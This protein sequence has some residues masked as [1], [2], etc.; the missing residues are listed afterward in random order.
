[1]VNGCVLHDPA[2]RGPHGGE[3][4]RL[5]RRHPRG[6]QTVP[7]SPSPAPSAP[8]LGYGLK[9]F[10]PMKLLRPDL[11]PIIVSIFTSIKECIHY[12]SHNTH[13]YSTGVIG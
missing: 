13:P 8:Y 6:Y 12:T 2:V 11:P 5:P 9:I 3:K 1:M 4:G 10:K 7:P